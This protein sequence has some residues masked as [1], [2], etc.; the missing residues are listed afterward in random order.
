VFVKTKQRER[1]EVDRAW[2]AY[3]R[4]IAEQHTAEED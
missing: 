3:Q 2:R 1:R 4:C